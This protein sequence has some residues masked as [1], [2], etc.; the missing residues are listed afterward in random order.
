M[1]FG[2]RKRGRQDGGWNGA[3]K[4]PR[5]EVESFTSGVGSK[6]KPCTKFFST[7]GCP[8]GEGCHF[9][10]YVPGGYSAVKQLTNASGPIGRKAPMQQP[11]PFAAD[12]PPTPLKSKLCKKINTPEGCKFG[13]K[14][15]FAHSELELSSK[16]SFPAYE[17]PR[18]QPGPI[19][20]GGGFQGR[21][22]PAPPGLAAAANF[23]QSAT[24]KISI[25]GALAGPIIGKGGVN[26]KQISRLTGVKLAIRD[27]ETDQNQKNVELEGTFDQIKQASAMVHELIMN[28][29]SSGGANGLPPRTSGGL[30]QQQGG[31]ANKIKTKICENFAKGQCTFGDKCHFAHGQNELRSLWAVVKQVYF[32]KTSLYSSSIGKLFIFFWV[33]CHLARFDVGGK[34]KCCCVRKSPLGDEDNEEHRGLRDHYAP[35]ALLRDLRQPLS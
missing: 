1:D 26:S 2:G 8:F 6:S 5:D 30:Q 10:H 28:L 29:G 15:R 24:A 34:G 4:R 21:M 11:P 18:G 19:N 20:Y 13:D 7:S 9:L 16:S 35:P 33:P 25:D 3:P 23:G 14:C 12:G 17:D 32:F 27:H 31:F 22:E